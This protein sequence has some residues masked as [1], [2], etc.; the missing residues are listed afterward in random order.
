MLGNLT[1]PRLL[2]T[3]V[4]NGPQFYEGVNNR[5]SG[6]RAVSNRRSL[7]GSLDEG[8]GDA[9][10][11]QDLG[12]VKSIHRAFHLTGL[13]AAIHQQGVVTTWGST[14]SGGDSSTVQGQLQDVRSYGC[15][16]LR[17]VGCDLG[18]PCIWRGQQRSSGA[19]S[20]RSRNTSLPRRICCP[21]IRRKGCHL[22]HDGFWRRQRQSAG[23]A[24]GR[25]ENSSHQQ[26]LCCCQ[27]RWLC[28][29]L[30]KQMAAGRGSSHV[31]EQLGQSEEELMP[32]KRPQA[33][34]KAKSTSPPNPRPNQKP[35]QNRKPRPNQKPNPRPKPRTRLNRKPRPRPNQTLRQWQS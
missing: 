34:V 5:S 21:T 27:G 4:V 18:M 24:P 8:T 7:L 12:V 10:Q 25:Q 6:H 30:G 3:F 35:R 23:P 31:R 19:A 2:G 17:Q 26:C 1:G 33:P 13:F 16:S 32:P 20:G 14:V 15:S 11:I 29:H 22:G 28:D 9:Q